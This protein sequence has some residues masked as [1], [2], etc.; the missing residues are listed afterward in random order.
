MPYKDPV[1]ARQCAR[2]GAR[3]RRA[4]NPKIREKQHEYDIRHY[5]ANKKAENERSRR[6]YQANREKIREQKLKT[7][8]GLSLNQWNQMF[9]TQGGVCAICSIGA[10][11]GNGWCTDHCHTTGRVRAILCG[12]CNKGLGHFK[13]SP[14]FLRGAAE[15]LEKHANREGT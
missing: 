11:G 10:P 15:Y 5:A 7:K 1:K 6:Q 9:A 2:E 12:H 8:Y 14:V 4:T 3:R 13:D